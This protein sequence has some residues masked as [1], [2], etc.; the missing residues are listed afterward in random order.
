MKG[1]YGDKM[2]HSLASRGVKTARA[3]GY[4]KDYTYFSDRS[5]LGDL[6]N[7]N[8]IEMFN[9]LV[10]GDTVTISDGYRTY[11]YAWIEHGKLIIKGEKKIEDSVEELYNRYQLYES[12]SF[13]EFEKINEEHYYPDLRVRLEISTD[14]PDTI[15]GLETKLQYF[16]TELE[17]EEG[18]ANM[19]LDKRFLRRVY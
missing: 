7:H 1:W 11:I 19:D 13:E 17:R 15:L 16:S 5:D 10:N 18:K 14:I 12:M 6:K 9:V 8:F 2:G 3:K 4:P